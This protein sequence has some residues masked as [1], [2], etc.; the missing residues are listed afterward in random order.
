MLWTEKEDKCNQ[1]NRGTINLTRWVEKQVRNRE[2]S[3]ASKTTQWRE[4]PHT[5]Q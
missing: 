1:E 5:F 2:E 4:L 3:N